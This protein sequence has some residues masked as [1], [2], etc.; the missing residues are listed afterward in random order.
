MGGC[1]GLWRVACGAARINGEQTASVTVAVALLSPFS[2]FPFGFAH[3]DPKNV[4]LR[5]RRCKPTKEL[6]EGAR[7]WR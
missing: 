7:F 6:E 5:M 4:N 3:E 2:P 1:G